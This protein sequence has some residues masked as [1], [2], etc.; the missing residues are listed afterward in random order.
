[1]CLQLRGRGG[2]YSKALPQFESVE[3][4]NVN[5]VVADNDAFID[6]KKETLPCLFR[7]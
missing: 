6:E 7:L 5:D 4:H 2:G 1:M 3:Y